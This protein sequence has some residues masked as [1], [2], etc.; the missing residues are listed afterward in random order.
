MTHPLARKKELDVE[1]RRRKVAA[2]LLSG[3]SN[4]TAIAEQLN[5]D[6]STISRDIKHIEKQWQAEAVQDIAAAKGKDLERTERLIA[7]LWEDARKGKW[8]ATDRVLALMQHRAKLLGLEA[9]QKQD[10]NMQHVI[11]EYIGIILEDV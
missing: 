1:A 10:L 3:V 8:L 5:V 2:I 9:P 7:A 4:K 6:R 11:R